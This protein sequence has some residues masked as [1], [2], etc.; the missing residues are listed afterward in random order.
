MSLCNLVPLGVSYCSL[1]IALVFVSFHSLGW[2]MITVTISTWI[3]YAVQNC[4]FGPFV[5][6]HIINLVLCPQSFLVLLE[7]GVGDYQTYLTKMMYVLDQ[8][9]CSVLYFLLQLIC[10][11]IT[12]KILSIKKRHTFF[13][14]SDSMSFKTES[15]QCHIHYM[16]KMRLVQKNV[17]LIYK[18]N[19]IIANG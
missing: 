17:N 15:V 11:L 9:R 13:C 19:T 14:S 16:K 8:L 6:S 18:V 3:Y 4:T 5:D 2:K 7:P 12:L 10:N 1:G